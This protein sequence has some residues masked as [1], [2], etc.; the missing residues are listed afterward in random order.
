MPAPIKPDAHEIKT[1]HPPT[2]TLLVAED[3]DDNPH[4]LLK[5]EVKCSPGSQN[6]GELQQ[7]P[8][9]CIQLLEYAIPTP[10]P[11][12]AAVS[13]KSPRCYGVSHVMVLAMLWCKPCYGVSNVMVLALFWC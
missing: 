5:C 8:I 4:E 10:A 6:R 7:E 13:P 12:A 1:R 2:T 3:E 11:A 9:P